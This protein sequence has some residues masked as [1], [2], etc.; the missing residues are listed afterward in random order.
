MCPLR[1]FLFSILLLALSS[2]LALRP[3]PCERDSFFCYDAREWRQRASLLSTPRVVELHVLSQRL[4]E[5]HTDIFAKILGGRGRESIVALMAHLN[6]N[7]VDRDILIYRPI[8]FEVIFQSGYDFCR[9]GDFENFNSILGQRGGRAGY[10]VEE[11]RRNLR[12]FCDSSVSRPP[13]H[14]V[15]SGD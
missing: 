5:P 9:S 3:N 1:A 13:E 6:N 4:I 12:I 11:E 14:R 2:C 8:L 7:P 10:S 15:R